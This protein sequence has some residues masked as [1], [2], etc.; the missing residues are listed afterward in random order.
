[1]IG[2]GSNLLVRDGGFHG[3]IVAL[4]ARLNELFLVK[5]D[6]ADGL[7]YAG[8]GVPCAKLARFAALHHLAGAEFL[9]GIPG[10]VGGALA[11]NAGCY[12]AE[13]WQIVEKVRTINR[14]GELHERNPED[15]LVGY[16]HVALQQKFSNV[17]GEEW[18]AGGWFRLERGDHDISRQKIKALLTAR[19]N[20]QPL[21]FPNAGSVFRNPAG[22]YAARLIEACGL[23]GYRVGG[24]MVSTKHANFI[25][26][27]GNATASDIEAIIAMIRNTVKERTGIELIQEVRIIGEVRSNGS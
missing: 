14:A 16:R 25:I 18:F 17:D 2:L 5:Q 24:A 4:H 6:Q 27:N 7:I 21:N 10:T 23:K 15:Y 26:N 11:M 12:G 13:T 3:V 8:A 9:A 22:D 20:S 19:I 1:M